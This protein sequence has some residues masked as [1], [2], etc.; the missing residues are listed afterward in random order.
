[1][2]WKWMTF[3][4][5]HEFDLEVIILMQRR[6]TDSTDNTTVF[7]ELTKDMR[8][9]EKEGLPYRLEEFFRL[10]TE[11]LMPIRPF[12]GLIIYVEFWGYCLVN[13][14]WRQVLLL[15]YWDLIPFFLFA[16]HLFFWQHHGAWKGSVTRRVLWLT[17]WYFRQNSG[18]WINGS[19]DKVNK[20]GA[21]LVSFGGWEE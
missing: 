6:V 4:L 20:V 21:I 13:H 17:S 18:E 11:D 19:N 9:K 2:W 7:L 10:K 5:Y 14:T 12:L 15:S 16:I 1:M 8:K 3:F